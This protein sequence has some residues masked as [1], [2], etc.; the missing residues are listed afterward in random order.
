MRKAAEALEQ[1]A[2]ELKGPPLTFAE[3]AVRLG[4]SV[5]QVE[6]WVEAGVL[7]TVAPPVPDARRRIP[8]SE[9]VRFAKPL[10]V[11]TTYEIEHITTK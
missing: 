9:F 11:S 1:L 7:K 3:F 5:R 10:G 8:W 2:A 6:K 4:Y